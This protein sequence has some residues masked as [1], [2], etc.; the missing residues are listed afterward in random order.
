MVLAVYDFDRF[1]KHDII[2]KIEIPMNSIDLG[3]VYEATKELE[4]ADKVWTKRLHNELIN[5][6]KQ[7]SEKLGDICFSLRYV[8]TSGKFNVVILEAKNLK[9]M[10]ACGLSDPYV[11]INLMMN[12]KRL[13]KKKTTV[14]KNTLSPYYNESFR[15]ENKSVTR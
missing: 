11:K 2:G 3:Q 8:P 12:G 13:K 6:N 9:K 15:Y 7:D 14:K 1:G 4:A 5:Q 10:D